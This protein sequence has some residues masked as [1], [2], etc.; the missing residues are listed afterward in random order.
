MHQVEEVNSVKD[1]NSDEDKEEEDNQ[2][3]NVLQ[4]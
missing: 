4:E 3:Q 2:L 1:N